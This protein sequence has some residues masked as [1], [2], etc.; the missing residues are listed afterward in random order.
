MPKSDD[1][2]SHNKPCTLCGTPRQ[3]LVRC[4]ID[5]GAQWHFVCPGKCW[6]SVSGGVEDAKGFEAEHPYY[7]YGGMWKNKHADGPLSAKKPKKVKDRQKLDR[8]ERGD[9]G[10][11]EA[12]ASEEE[13]N[14]VVQP[15]GQEAQRH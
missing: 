6:K 2:E 13:T 8:A 12:T 9:G 11:A 14:V 4:Q 15:Q 5:E 10:S 3:V 7:R 1:P